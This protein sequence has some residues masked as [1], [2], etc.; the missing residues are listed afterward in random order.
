MIKGLGWLGTR[1]ERYSELVAFYRDGMRLELVR[2]DEGMAVFELPDGSKVE[3][4]AP[5]EP[6]HLHFTTGPVAGFLVDDIEGARRALE[7][8]GA[9]FLGPIQTWEPT[10][11]AWSHFRAPD[12][13][14][15]EL[16]LRRGA[17]PG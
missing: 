9:E 15:Y 1:T 10:G 13:N 17:K 11:E 6:H 12:G 14:I 5:A 3:V 16:T 8:A 4:F 7:R 2:E